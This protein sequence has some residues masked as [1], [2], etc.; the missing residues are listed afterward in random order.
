MASMIDDS[1]S[2]DVTSEPRH[3]FVA[4]LLSLM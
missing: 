1:E 3:L 2:F 4:L